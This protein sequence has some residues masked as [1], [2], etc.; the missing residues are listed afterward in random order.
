MLREIKHSCGHIETYQIPNGKFSRMKKFYHERLCKECWKEQ[1]QD[2]QKLAKED[3]ARSGLPKLTGPLSLVYGAEL[4]RY[5][6]FKFITDNSEDLKYK[7]PQF[8]FAVDLLRSKQKAS[9]WHAHKRERFVHLFDVAMDHAAH[10]LRLKAL[11]PEIQKQLNSLHMVPLSGS[12]KQIQWAESI[13]SKILLDLIGVELCLEEALNDKE[14]WA[15]FMVQLCHDLEP[16]P[17][18]LRKMTKDL[19]L[20]DAAGHWI[21]IRNHSLEDLVRWMKRPESLARTL[22]LVQ[23]RFFFILN[24]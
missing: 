10:Q 11:A 12:T 23:G 20:M 1:E 15:E 9:W 17:D 16:V 5:E 8:Q 3:N 14:E 7:G 4:I 6:F 21:E 19:A 22:H 24:L 18:L 2:K 13:R